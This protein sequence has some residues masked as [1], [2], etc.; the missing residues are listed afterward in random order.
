MTD[1]Y[2]SKTLATW[3]AFLGGSLGLH[4]FYLYG[5]RDVWGWVWTVPTLIGGIGLRRFLTLG[6]E[7]HLAQIL[8]PFLGLSLAAGALAALI[9]GL[10]PDEKWNARFNPNGPEH[11][12]GWLTIIGVV[13][14]LLIGAT[15]LMSTIA[16]SGGWYFEYQ[17]SQKASSN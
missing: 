10:M 17:A 7:D 16:A 14:S 3:V 2:K 15:V 11:A 8:I 1:G 13:F 5:L 9:Y 6:Q 12:T 4:R